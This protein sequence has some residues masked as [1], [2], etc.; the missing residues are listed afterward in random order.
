[1][2]S[3]TRDERLQKIRSDIERYGNSVALVSAGSVPR[4]AYTIGLREAIGFE[5]VMPGALYYTAKEVQQIV[6]AC[7]VALRADPTLSSLQ[8]PS[9]GLFSLRS[10]HDSWM[11]SMAL[12]AMDF[13]GVDVVSGV[14]VVPDADHQTIDVPSMEQD[15]ASSSE[16]VW[17]WLDQPWEYP[18][19]EKSIATTNLAALR[20]SPITELARWE[21]DEWEVFAGAGPDVEPSEMRVVPL[22]TLIAHDPSLISTLSVGIGGGFWR[23]SADS[24]WNEWKRRS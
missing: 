9:I 17:R 24:V 5:L 7:A 1:M 6:N 8:V 22:S 18:V 15:R 16:P 13:Y 4:Y 11:R 2:N 21:D 19:P 20:G 12:G 10:A 14:Q 23:E 3:G